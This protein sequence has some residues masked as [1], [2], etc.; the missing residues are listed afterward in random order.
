MDELFE[1][2]ASMVETE[3]EAFRAGYLAK[4][5]ASE[6]TPSQFDAFLEDPRGYVKSAGVSDSILKLLGLKQLGGVGSSMGGMGLA[7]AGGI[8]LMLGG[9][10]GYGLANMNTPTNKDIKLMEQEA[11]ADT[12]D[13]H[14]R[15]LK[16]ENKLYQKKKKDKESGKTRSMGLNDYGF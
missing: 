4:L 11:I 13:Y 1:K 9:A 16:G 8:P 14:T 3:E 7:L 6:I 15:R 2:I 10:A 5:A 12:Y